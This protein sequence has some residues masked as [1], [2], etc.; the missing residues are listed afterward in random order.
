MY[1]DT[2]ECEIENICEVGKCK[3]I[4]GG[5]ECVCNAGYE[6]RFGDRTTCIGYDLKCVIN[7]I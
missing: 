6:H 1:I 5:Y 2:D 7:C 3:N 4:I